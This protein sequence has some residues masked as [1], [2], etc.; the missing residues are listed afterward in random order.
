TVSFTDGDTVS[1]TVPITILDDTAFEGNETVNIALSNPT[2]GATV[3]S[4]GTA[5]L[6]I[7][8]NETAF[9]VSV[10]TRGNG[11]VTSNP[12]GINCGTDCSEPYLAGTMVTLN[13]IPSANFIFAGWSGACSGTGSCVVTMNAAKSVTATFRRK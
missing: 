4:P 13:P 3:G 11:D 5:V 1:K 2:G 9:P 10:S 6:T 8:D 12:A 7:V